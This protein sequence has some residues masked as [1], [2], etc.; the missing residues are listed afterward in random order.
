MRL[1]LW[2]GMASPMAI[3]VVIG[4]LV[5]LALEIFRDHDSPE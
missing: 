3:F 5:W 2:I 4:L 1:L